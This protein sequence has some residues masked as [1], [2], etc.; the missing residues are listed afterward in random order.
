M[1]LALSYHIEVVV[2][3]NSYF[4]LKNFYNASQEHR[5]SIP[6]TIIDGEGVREDDLLNGIPENSIIDEYI[7]LYK[8][9]VE[10]SLA[11]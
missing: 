4:V 11:Y 7:R 1:L 5:K 2:F 8:E 6:I 3:S 10:L 9:E